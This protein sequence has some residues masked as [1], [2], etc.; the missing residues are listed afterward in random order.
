MP[1]LV[2]L[3]GGDPVA[4]VRIAAIESLGEIGDA[5]GIAALLPIVAD[6]DPAIATPA[7]LALGGAGNPSVLP[8]LVGELAGADRGRCLAALEAIARLAHPAAVPS[9]AAVARAHAEPELRERAT[10]ALARIGEP[11]AIGALAALAEDP[12]RGADVV[13]ALG[14]LGEK[15]V[16]I[17][18]RE[19][20]HPDVGVRC[21]VVEALGRMR[22]PLASAALA[23]ALRDDAPIV[24]L[25]AAHALARLDLRATTSY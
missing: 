13:A 17:V 4:P 23:R 7:M 10:L 1:V 8:L 25:A 11:D 3:A 12:A 2:A 18:A 22:S 20:A 14:Q 6:S 24:Q 9:V 21:V 16:P 19:L 15:H 5:D